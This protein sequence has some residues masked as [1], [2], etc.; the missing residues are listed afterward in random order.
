MA[1]PIKNTEHIWNFE[2]IS[3]DN[4]PAFQTNP[5]IASG[6][7]TTSLDGSAFSNMDT[8]PVVTASGVVSVKLVVS[9]AETEACFSLTV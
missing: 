1:Y 8:L 9:A 6:D 4:R 3:T 2:Y 5:T 7:V